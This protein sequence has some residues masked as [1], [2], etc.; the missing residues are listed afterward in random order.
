MF[1]QFPELVGDQRRLR[2]LDRGEPDRPAPEPGADGVDRPIQRP[3]GG[4]GGGAG[5]VDI[6]V[7]GQREDELQGIPS[8]K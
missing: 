3:P 4:R 6:A 8:H 7:E 5:A 2:Q 1:G